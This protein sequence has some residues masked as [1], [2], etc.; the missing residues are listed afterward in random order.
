MSR[1]HALLTQPVPRD[2]NTSRAL[3]E[4]L[5]PSWGFGLYFLLY[6]AVAFSLTGGVI[7]LASMALIP[8]YGKP[9]PG[10]AQAIA[11]GI[12]LVF[13]LLMLLP[14]FWW[15]GRRRRGL[16]SLARNGEALRG[17][18]ERSN[19]TTF[20]GNPLTG[21]TILAYRGQEP[22]RVDVT[23]TAHAPCLDQGAVIDV[24]VRDGQRYAAV[25]ATD[26]KVWVGTR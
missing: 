2:E 26:G 13:L 16:T 8:H 17:M 20:R 12:S 7:V 23:A 15:A 10:E 19:R 14:F 25:F 11:G 9:L 18:V 3:A 22:I 6:F 24:I 5:S 21:L 4:K 1:F